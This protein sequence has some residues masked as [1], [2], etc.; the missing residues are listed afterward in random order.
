MSKRNCLNIFIEWARSVHFPL[1]PI[2]KSQSKIEFVIMWPIA[3]MKSML[4]LVG[5]FVVDIILNQ[6]SRLT[7][8][9]AFLLWLKWSKFM[10]KSPPPPKKFYLS[11]C[12]LLG[13]FLDRTRMSWNLG[14]P[15]GRLFI[16]LKSPFKLPSRW[17]F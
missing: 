2:L 4:T 15:F 13:C 14:L 8:P 9:C 3:V 10:L 7:K 6:N 1:F 11:H 5:L 12:L 16:Y 17:N